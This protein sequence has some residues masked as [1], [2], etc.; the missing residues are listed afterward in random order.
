MSEDTQDLFAEAL[1]IS[2]KKLQAAL[3]M[4]GK[5]LAPYIAVTMM[6][7]SVNE[8]AEHIALEDIAG[9]LEELAGQIRADIEEK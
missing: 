3:E 1:T 7:A 5:D 9:M 6:E 4:G 8:A 2:E